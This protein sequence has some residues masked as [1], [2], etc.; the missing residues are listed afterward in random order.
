MLELDGD[1]ALSVADARTYA[2]KYNI[3][4]IT[5]SDLLTALGL[6]EKI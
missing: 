1:G 2:K 3:P 5:G 4:M 6:D